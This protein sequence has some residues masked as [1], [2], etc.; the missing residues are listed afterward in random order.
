[1]KRSEMIKKI[2]KILRTWEDCAL[3]D[4]ASEEILSMMEEEGIEPPSFVYWNSK[5]PEDVD[6]SGIPK[7]F[8]YSMHNG[9]DVNWWEQE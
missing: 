5:N 9:D 2:T 7:Q 8:E 1:M 4:K 3:T 6:E